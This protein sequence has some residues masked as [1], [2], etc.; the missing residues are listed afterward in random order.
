MRNFLWGTTHDK[1]AWHTISWEKICKPKQ[2]GGLGIRKI[3][4]F[5]SAL[6]MKLG[7]G[8]ITHSEAFWHVLCC[9]RW[10]LGNGRK[11]LFWKHVWLPRGLN[12][13]AL[14]TTPV[15]QELLYLPVNAFKRDSEWD[16]SLFRSF[17]PDWV[18]NE[19][20]NHP[21]GS[22]DLGENANSRTHVWDRIWR[23]DGPPRVH[24]FL[25]TLLRGGLKTNVRRQKCLPDMSASCPLCLHADESP[26]HILRDCRVTRRV[27]DE[28]R[29]SQRDMPSSVGMLIW[30]IGLWQISTKAVIGISISFFG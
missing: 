27:W 21:V 9:M 30:K 5:N 24:Y 17:L 14:A 23:W 4:D 10:I 25:W 3:H 6:L 20:V 8:L 26:T 19:I 29:G 22:D 18:V 1:K 15:P 28:L 13:E 7:W 2:L 11:I 12:L 16:V